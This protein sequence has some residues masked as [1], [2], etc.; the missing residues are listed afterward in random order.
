MKTVSLTEAGNEHAEQILTQE[1]L[2]KGDSLY[3]IENVTAVHHINQALRAHK[4]FQRDKDYI[5]KSDQ[6]VIIDE[7]TG[8]MMTTMRST[9][10]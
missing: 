2:L 1:G 7:F 4:L 9:R 5:V 8:R 10:R 3:D 6:V